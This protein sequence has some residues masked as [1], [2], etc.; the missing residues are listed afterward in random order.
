MKPG[1]AI[2]DIAIDQGGSIL[3]PGYR[4]DDSAAASLE[5]YRTLFADYAYYAETN[6]PRE[7]PREAS[8]RHGDASWLYVTTLLA[9]TALHG[10]PEAT[11]K[12]LLSHPVR[13]FRSDEGLEE[14]SLLE[15]LSQ[16]LRNGLQLAV[17]GM[18]A[19]I[20]DPEVGKN[21]ALARW[22]DQCAAA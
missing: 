6:M 12:Q 20:M 7:V 14:R 15:C 5:K 8:Q 2:V 11:A 1:A 16:D 3:H 9:L 19:G 10:G 4:E 21:E 22:V 13:Y 17:N 18:S